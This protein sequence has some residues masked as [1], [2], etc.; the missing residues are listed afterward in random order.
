MRVDVLSLWLE[1]VPDRILL[2]VFGADIG[3]SIFTQF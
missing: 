2:S 1:S 3:G